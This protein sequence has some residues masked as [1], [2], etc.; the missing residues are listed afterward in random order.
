MTN[1]TIK[2][3]NNPGLRVSGISSYLPGLN[4]LIEFSCILVIHTFTWNGITQ[5]IRI[6]SDTA[7][8]WF[9]ALFCLQSYYIL[10][11]HRTDVHIWTITYPFW[12]VSVFIVSKLHTILVMKLHFTHGL[13]DPSLGA[14]V[15]LGCWALIWTAV[16]KRKASS[17]SC[18]ICVAKAAQAQ[19][20][21]IKHS[22]HRMQQKSK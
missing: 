6:Y 16:L 2:L 22:Q 3:L 11:S 21:S 18:S 1:S 4:E 15:I 14:T 9:C 13:N 10:F 12:K 8:T 19:Q 17:S 7:R 20:K 5:W